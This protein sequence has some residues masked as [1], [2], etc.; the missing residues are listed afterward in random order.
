MQVLHSRS[1]GLLQWRCWQAIRHRTLLCPPRGKPPES[2]KSSH[3]STE[4]ATGCSRSKLEAILFHVPGR[5]NRYFK[6]YLNPQPCQESSKA[7]STC[8]HLLKARAALWWVP[9]NP[10]SNI[11][12]PFSESSLGQ[13]DLPSIMCSVL[14]IH[15]SF[16]LAAFDVY[17]MLP[18]YHPDL[19]LSPVWF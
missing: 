7:I 2:F 17:W 3:Q 8:T 5:L 6:D 15:I 1:Q 13:Y 11:T 9:R 19:A 16:L 14:S 10:K 12:S 18:V 4:W